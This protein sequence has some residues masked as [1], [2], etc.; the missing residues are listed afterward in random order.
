ME[1]MYSKDR[2][3]E[4]NIQNPLNIPNNYHPTLPKKSNEPQ[5]KPQ[6]NNNN[7]Y[8]NK[9]V[10]KENRNDTLDLSQIS[11]KYLK[12]A[13][14][15]N[16]IVIKKEAD[17][18]D[19]NEI[20]DKENKLKP[21]KESLDV[22]VTNKKEIEYEIN[23][24][25]EIFLVETKKKGNENVEK[26]ENKLADIDSQ[27]EKEKEI[28]EEKAEVRGEKNDKENI[29]IKEIDVGEKDNITPEIEQKIVQA[30]KANPEA[31]AQAIQ[32]AVA[33]EEGKNISVSDVKKV[34]QK[35]ELSD[36]NEKGEQE[37][38][39]EKT[40]AGK[41]TEEAKRQ[42]AE[43]K[44][45]D[46]AV[47]AHEMAHVAAGGQYVQG[48]PKYEYQKG[49][50][51]RNYAVG[52]SVSLDTGEEK[53]PEETI[54]KAQIVRRAALAPANPSSTD[55]QVAAS[56]SG[57][58]MKARQKLT[59]EKMEE[60]KEEEEKENNEISPEVER[61][62]VQLKKNNPNLEAEDISRQV[63]QSEDIKLPKNKIMSILRKYDLEDDKEEEEEEKKVEKNRN[64]EE[65]NWNYLKNKDRLSRYLNL[66][67]NYGQHLNAMA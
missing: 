45:I 33:G 21:E 43:L 54:R 64:K 28:T 16:N 7:V 40:P 26:E 59:K 6:D 22:A 2:K 67:P 18:T 31:S 57:M 12:L 10:D 23:K 65:E 47:K 3:M 66:F 29:D 60:A 38:K 41:L 34:L 46:T 51:G 62:I 15:T 48:G 58:E 55:R 20:G 39:A 8:L 49:P 5:E 24:K 44:R 42:V 50:D 17:K 11:K 19:A 9:D 32:E 56:A 14:A 1:I 13:N 63:E 4:I 35:N 27:E 61:K 25:E 36:E 52:G 30:K 53:N 37:K